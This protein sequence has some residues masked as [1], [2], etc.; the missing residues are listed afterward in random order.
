LRKKGKRR[1]IFGG[2]RGQKMTYDHGNLFAL[3][4]GKSPSKTHPNKRKNLN[5]TPEVDPSREGEKL[6][7][8]R[9]ISN[10]PPKNGRISRGGVV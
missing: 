4:T 1:S 10:E 2:K 6:R 3:R 5:H 7:R 8:S 9:K